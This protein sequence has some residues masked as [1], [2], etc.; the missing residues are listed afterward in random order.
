MFMTSTGCKGLG[1]LTKNSIFAVYLTL[2]DITD[3][4]H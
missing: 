3:Y 1:N 4:S 2:K